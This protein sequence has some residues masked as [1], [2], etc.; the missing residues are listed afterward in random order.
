MVFTYD[1]V[2]IIIVFFN[3]FFWIIAF[4]GFFEW[5][6]TNIGVWQFLSVVLTDIVFGLV[7]IILVVWFLWVELDFQEKKPWRRLAPEFSDLVASKIIS[8]K[9]MES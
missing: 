8:G 9:G 4:F 2:T 1:K 5:P 3:P 7:T 6:E